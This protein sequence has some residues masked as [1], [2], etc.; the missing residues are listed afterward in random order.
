MRKERAMTHL[1]VLL[2]LKEGLAQ[3]DLTACGGEWTSLTSYM[4]ADCESSP[5]GIVKVRLGNVP[6]DLATCQCVDPPVF[7]TAR[8]W[9]S[10][11]RR[12]RIVPPTQ[13]ENV[14]TGV[15]SNLGSD[16][17][18][19]DWEID[20]EPGADNVTVDWGGDID[21]EPGSDNV[22]ADWEIDTEPGAENASEDGDFDAEVALEKCCCG[23]DFFTCDLD[24]AGEGPC[25]M[26]I[27]MERR[28][29]ANTLNKQNLG[30]ELMLLTLAVTCV[31][32]SL[33]FERGRRAA[34]YHALPDNDPE[35][36]RSS[37]DI[38]MGP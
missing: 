27:V 11:R 32:V 33:Y 24:C 29:D 31:V 14:T 23:A 34:I 17:V 16:N 2:V 15:G 3:R 18:T 13:P 28:D 26:T 19:A 36:R 8:H 6:D 1:I 22:T 10:G 30:M 4:K 9:A 25:N 5:T 35:S 7:V 37:R 12:A 38:P 21:L 20:T